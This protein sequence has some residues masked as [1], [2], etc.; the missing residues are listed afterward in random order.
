MKTD[1]R[2]LSDSDILHHI[3]GCH[4][5]AVK[6]VGKLGLN[7]Y[8]TGRYSV[9]PSSCTNVCKLSSLNPYSTGRYSVS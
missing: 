7:P 2:T 8:S 3:T 6:Y 4:E 1:Y 9:R 5:Q